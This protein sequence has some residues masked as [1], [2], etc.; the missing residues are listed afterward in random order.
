[1]IAFLNE[2]I[3]G[4][5]HIF[6][7]RVFCYFWKGTRVTYTKGLYFQIVGLIDFL[8]ARAVRGA[9]GYKYLSLLPVNLRIVRLQLYEFKNKV[10]LTET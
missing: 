7:C 10:L 6:I 8:V 4:D 3:Q 5:Q 2:R 9:A 1:M